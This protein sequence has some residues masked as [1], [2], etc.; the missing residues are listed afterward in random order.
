MKKSRKRALIVLNGDPPSLQFLRN[1]ARRADLIVAADGGANALRKARV[2]ADVIIGDLD[3]IQPATKR[4]FAHTRII[5]VPDQDSTDFE[6]ALS[7][8]KRNGIVDVMVTGMAGRRIDFALGNFFSIWK[9]TPRFCFS[10]FGDG[11]FAFP[12]RRK[13]DL[14]L[15]IGTTVSLIP[16]GRLTGVTLRGF[17][18]PLNGKTMADGSLGVSNVTIAKKV[19]IHLRTGK[20]LVVVLSK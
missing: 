3:S 8:L 14:F 16:F 5:R 9:Y 15:P 1:L 17:Q 2:A 18:F 4:H 19:S 7:F 6:K 12:V 20:L 11:W 13:L 10:L